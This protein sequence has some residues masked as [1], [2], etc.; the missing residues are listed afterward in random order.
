MA[1]QVEVLLT[2]EL[3][4][5]LQKERFVTI[6]TVDHETSGPNVSAISWVFAPTKETVRFAVDNRSRIIE[7]IK[8][9]SQV[10]LNV[11][12]NESTYSIS[13]TASVKVEKLEEVPL[14][15]ALV[16]IQIKEVRDVMFYGSKISVEPQYE[17]TYD[18][19]AAEKL[20][21]QVMTAMK[22]A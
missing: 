5:F 13:G 11:I 14:K 16:E 1:N 22:K 9:N 3:F 20:D 2:D 15:L 17:K 12:G 6:A 19:E 4:E 10:V 7:N 18:K 8:G 21:N